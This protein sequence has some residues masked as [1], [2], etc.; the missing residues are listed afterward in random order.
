MARR[1]PYLTSS[2]GVLKRSSFSKWLE[3]GLS[4]AQGKAGRGGEVGADRGLA[5]DTRT[6]SYAGADEKAGPLREILEDL[7]ELGAQ[8]LGRQLRGAREELVEGCTLQRHDAQ[9]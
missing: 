9:L 5:D 2:S 4:R 1:M 6:P 8:T 3:I 7:A